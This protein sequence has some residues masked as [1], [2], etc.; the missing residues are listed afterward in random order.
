MSSVNKSIMTASPTPRTDFERFFMALGATV[1]KVNLSIS[2]LNKDFYG[3]RMITVAQHP[4]ETE[5]RL[6]LRILA[7]SLFAHEEDV[8]FGRGVSTEGEPALWCIDPTGRI[9]SW[10]ELG[11]PDVKSIRK[12]AGRSDAVSIFAYGDDRI[13]EWWRGKAG[14]FSKIDKLTV[15][16]IRDGELDKLENLHSRSMSFTVTI[17]DNCIWWDSGKTS[18]QIEIEYMKRENE[19]VYLPQMQ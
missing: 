10:V 6:M 16:R 14:D 8:D 19:K 3:D 5:R 2:N 15:C 18:I 7:Y 4:S 11:C 13:D 1:H 12:A 9:T 17:Q